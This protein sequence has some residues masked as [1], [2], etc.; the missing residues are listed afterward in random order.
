MVEPG[1]DCGALAFLDHLRSLLKFQN[2]HVH[3]L[4]GWSSLSSDPGKSVDH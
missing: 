4:L 2:L 1:A 3:T